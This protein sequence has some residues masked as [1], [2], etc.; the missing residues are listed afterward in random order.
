MQN[1]I[2]LLE[3]PKEGATRAPYRVMN[4]PAIYARE[5]ER[6]F[7]GPTWHYLCLEAEIP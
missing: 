5:Q 3:W 7:R 4:D 2:P 6:I 1:E